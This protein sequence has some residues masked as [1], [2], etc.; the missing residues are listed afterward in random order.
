MLAEFH[1]VTGGFNVH[2]LP[3]TIKIAAQWQG[4]LLN[5][6][7]RQAYFLHLLNPASPTRAVQNDLK[8]QKIWLSAPIDYPHMPI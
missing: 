4:F 6:F 5:L 2:A 7:R 3:V 1:F 8:S